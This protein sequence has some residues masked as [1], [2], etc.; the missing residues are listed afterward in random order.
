MWSAVFP[1]RFSP[2]CVAFPGDRAGFPFPCGQQRAAIPQAPAV[3]SPAVAQGQHLL[4]P[5]QPRGQTFLAV[6]DVSQAPST[7]PLAQPPICLCPWPHSPRGGWEV[8]V[9]GAGSPSA[10]NAFGQ[11]TKHSPQ[12][13]RWVFKAKEQKGLFKKTSTL[14]TSFQNFHF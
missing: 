5:R 11:V 9:F 10:A 6:P 3:P 8:F 1:T 7:S 14:W 2:D 4:W 12:A 13:A